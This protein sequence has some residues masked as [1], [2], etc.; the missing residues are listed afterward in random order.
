[1]VRYGIGCS[2]QAMMEIVAL[3]D[4]PPDGEGMRAGQ[5]CRPHEEA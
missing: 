2:P 4:V 1:L 3:G 5:Q